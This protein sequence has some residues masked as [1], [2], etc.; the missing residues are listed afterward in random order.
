MG[1]SHPLLPPPGTNEENLVAQA[2]RHQMVATRAAVVEAFTSALS[3]DALSAELLLFSIISRVLTRRGEAPIGKLALNISGC[4]AALTAGKAS[5]VWSSLLN[6]LRE[7]LPTVYGMPLTLQKL[8]DSKLIPEKDYEANVLLY[9]ELQL[10]AGST[11]LLDET[12]L[13]PGKLTEAGVRNLGALGDLVARQK[14]AFDFKYFP[15]DFESDVSMVS[16]STAQSVL[17]NSAAL[18]QVPLAVCPSGAPMPAALSDA[19][20]LNAARCYLGFASRCVGL[21]MPEPVAQALQN[22]FVNARKAN[23]QISPD[24]FAHWLTCSRLY[25]ASLLANQIEESHYAYARQ[26]EAERVA[27]LRPAEVCV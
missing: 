3:G 26:L 25:A 16:V 19:S 11:L 9:G 1:K 18:C 14:V 15:V 27:R 2:A 8:N 22:D 7:L 4:P 21:E 17:S 12:T 23:Q 24:D 6:I 5:P 10:P 13:T 20:F